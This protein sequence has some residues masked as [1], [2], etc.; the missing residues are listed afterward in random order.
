MALKHAQ[1]LDVMDVSPLGDKLHASV[2][3]SLLKTGTLQLM[4]VVLLAGHSLPEHHVAGEMTVQCLEGEAVVT[5]PHRV[6]TLTAGQLLTLP[7]GEPHAVT[8][9]TDTS[10]LVTVLLAG[11][12]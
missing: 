10:L 12:A 2:T 7:G 9:V 1:P 6:C 4:R 8:A 11:Q 5:T 3:H